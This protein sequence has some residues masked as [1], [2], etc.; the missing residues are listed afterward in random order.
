MNIFVFVVCGSKEHLDTLHFS[1]GKLKRYSQNKIVVLTD[2]TRN[3]SEINHDDVI[4]VDTPKELDHHQAS[5]YL[6]TA[7]H[8]F[9]PLG[10]TYCYLDTDVVALNAEV[11]AIFDEYQEPITFA[12]DHCKTLDF[13]PYAVNCGCK[14]RS[15]KNIEIF[16]RASLKHDRNRKI[17]DAKII[18]KQKKLQ[19]YFD[20]LK[21]DW[22]RKIVTALR[23][24]L[25]PKIFN[26]NEDFYFDKTQRVWKDSKT[27]ENILYEVDIKKIEEES[28]FKYNKWTQKW[29][30]KD[31]KD[32]WDLHCSHLN[33]Y[34]QNSFNI[35]VASP[36]W[37]HWN[38][39]VFL[40]DDK[41]TDFLNAWHEKTLHAFALKEWKTRDQGTLIASAWQFGLQNH[42]TLSKKWNFI[43]DF[44]KKG[45][46]FNDEG[47]FSDD[48][49]KTKYKASFVHI[50]HHWG[51]E[52][53]SLWKWVKNKAS[54]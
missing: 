4:H 15:D 5:I 30:D 7:I 31:R 34:I 18:E 21:N 17:E 35:K 36:N 48:A 27:N 8:K 22:P 47:Y 16:E 52:N 53:W 13:S 26:L 41:S 10:Q 29:L 49:W 19:H 44:N 32:I 43:A 51:D 42:K 23:Y 1:L 24:F 45:L 46:N 50:Y 6:K 20:V 14:E 3:E 39:G 38:G 2:K 33:E 11:D 25:A 37:Q 28:G 9:L 40:F 12:P 54:N